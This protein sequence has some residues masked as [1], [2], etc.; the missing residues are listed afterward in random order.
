MPPLRMCCQE[1]GERADVG[2]GPY[3]ENYWWMY[4]G[5]GV[6][7]SPPYASPCYA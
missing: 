2:I 5:A 6:L 3:E 4:V 1:C 7:D